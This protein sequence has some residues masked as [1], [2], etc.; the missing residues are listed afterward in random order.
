V[1]GPQ[2]PSTTSPFTAPACPYRPT[3][4]RCC[5]NYSR[6]GGTGTGG[7]YTYTPRPY[8]VIKQFSF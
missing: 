5:E 1:K 7:P 3:R 2:A 8:V 4:A 6:K